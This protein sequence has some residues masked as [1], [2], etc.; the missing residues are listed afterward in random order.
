MNRP[1][2]EPS[3]KGPHKSMDFSGAKT[4]PLTT[5]RSKV[6]KDLLADP[7]AYS[8]PGRSLEDLIPSI[9]K[10]SDIKALADAWAAAVSGG[11]SVILGMGAHPVKVGLSRLIIDLMNRGFVNALAA[12]GA[13]AVHDIEMAMQ[14]HTSEEVAEGLPEGAFGMAE[15][16]GRAYWD[17]VALAGR[18]GCGLGQA[19]GRHIAEGAFPHR[20]LSLLAAAYAR[21][22]PATLHVAIGTDIVHMHPGHDGA[23]L[24]LAA[25]RDFQVFSEAV[26]GL[27]GGGVYLNLGSAVIMPEVFLKAVNIARN[28]GGKPHGIVTANLDMIQ[29]YRPR[30]NVVERPTIPGGRGFQITGH[31]EILFPLLYTMVRDRLS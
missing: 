21:G 20:D 13:L 2:S 30:E 12:G 31:H 5:R 24:G 10:G 11:R 23:A 26:L 22:I 29:H 27:E 16:T 19:V 28:L 3:G 1:I 6:Q 4:A 18:E 7:E 25:F 9:L 15:E 17:A 14:G 8:P